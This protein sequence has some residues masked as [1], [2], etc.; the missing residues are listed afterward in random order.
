MIFVFPY[1]PV[2]ENKISQI[3]GISRLFAFPT[4]PT[5]SNNATITI[6]DSGAFGLSLVKQ[7]TTTNYMQRLSKHYETHYTANVLCI[8]PDEFLNPSTSMFN[9]LKWHKLGLFKNV[10]PVLQAQSKD[11]IDITDLCKQADF[12]R[13][14]SDTICFSNNGL[15][16]E[17]AMYLRLNKLFDY[18]IQLDFKWVHVLGAGWNNEDIIGWSQFDGVSSIDTIAYYKEKTEDE[19]L[20]RIEEI[21]WLNL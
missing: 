13:K 16:S 21:R 7:K 17:K 10:T 20:K 5:F 9:F 4:I 18:L 19:I 1:C 11:L 3:D 15:T 2:C 12:Y 6:L 14:Y 8:A